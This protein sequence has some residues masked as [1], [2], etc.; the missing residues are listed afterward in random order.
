MS[1]SAMD[2]AAAAAIAI[3]VALVLL[4]LFEP[5]LPYRTVERS[6]EV[7]SRRF[8]NFLGAIVNARLFSPAGVD[9]LASGAAIYAAQ[10]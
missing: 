8:V 10:L 1:L 3:V 6:M 9:V 4:V 7:G 5:S 2:L